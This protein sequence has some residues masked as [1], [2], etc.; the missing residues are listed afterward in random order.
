MKFGEGGEKRESGEGKRS[1]TQVHKQN[2][3]FVEVENATSEELY[4]FQQ[5]THVFPL[6]L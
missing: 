4:F 3:K 6:I 2:T 5:K 1:R